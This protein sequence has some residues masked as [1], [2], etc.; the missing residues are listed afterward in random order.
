MFSEESGSEN[1]IAKTFRTFPG[2][3]DLPKLNRKW[4]SFVKH[5]DC[6]K[7][8]RGYM[9]LPN[10]QR[11]LWLQLLTYTIKRGESAAAWFDKNQ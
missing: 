2:D 5:V 4:S 1:L 6:A 11:C 3:P 9:P 10:A 7:Q 8:A